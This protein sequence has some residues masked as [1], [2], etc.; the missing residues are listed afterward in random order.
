M[1]LYFWM[2]LLLPDELLQRFWIKS[3]VV[4]FTSEAQF[5]DQPVAAL[6][7]TA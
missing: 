4:V 3:A 7:V 5:A 2:A 1:Q 6:K